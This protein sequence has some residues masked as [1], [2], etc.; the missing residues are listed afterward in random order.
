MVAASNP[1]RLEIEKAKKMLKVYSY[2][3]VQLIWHALHLLDADTASHVQLA[4]T[5]ASTYRC[6][7]K[8]YIC[9]RW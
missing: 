7:L 3:L 8:A 1:D 6:N 9:V 4:G 5:R 2:L